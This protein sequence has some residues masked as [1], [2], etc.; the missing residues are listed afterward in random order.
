[1]QVRLPEDR[2]QQVCRWLATHGHCKP[3]CYYCEH[4]DQYRLHR[5]CDSEHLEQE[6]RW[7]DIIVTFSVFAGVS[8][9]LL[10]C[11]TSC[12][13]EKHCWRHNDFISRPLT[14]K[15]KEGDALFLPIV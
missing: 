4:N 3:E 6:L 5:R 7:K 1:M 11:Q 13:S 15:Q 2:K 14:K 8:L 12:G 9:L 10:L